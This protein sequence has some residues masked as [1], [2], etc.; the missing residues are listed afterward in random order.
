[1]TRALELVARSGGRVTG[2]EIA[3]PRQTAVAAP[4][5]Q[6]DMGVAT[7]RVKV[8]QPSWRFRQFSRAPTAGGEAAANR[9]PARMRADRPGA[10]AVFTF[11][12]SAA[13]ILGELSTEGGRADVYLDGQPA[14]SIDAYVGERT[15]DNTLWHAYGL[16]PGEHTVRIVARK[17]ADSRSAGRTLSI[18]EA[19]VYRAR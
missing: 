5:E 13:A 2:D 4:L 19:V 3:V 16:T 7:A 8:D 10:E 11:T 18:E 12:G 14:R 6:W 15:Y 9:P 17:D 1:V